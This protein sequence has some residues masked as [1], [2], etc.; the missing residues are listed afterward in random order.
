[1]ANRLLRLL[2]IVLYCAGI[3]I[4]SGLPQV[5][6]TVSWIPDK[7]GHFVLYAGLGFLVAREIRHGG[8]RTSRWIWMGSAIFCLFYGVTDELHQSVVPGRSAEIRD[9][10]ADTAGGFAAGVINVLWKAKS[11]TPVD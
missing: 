7:L 3:F 4:L 5:P 8:V 1:M 9:V 11:R 10:A 2:P 6:D